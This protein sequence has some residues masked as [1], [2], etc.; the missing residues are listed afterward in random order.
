[1]KMSVRTF[2]RR[3]FISCMASDKNQC[4]TYMRYRK[5]VLTTT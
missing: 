5:D 1:M 3:T 2:Q 4:H